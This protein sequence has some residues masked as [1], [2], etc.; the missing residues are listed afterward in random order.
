VGLNVVVGGDHSWPGPQL[1]SSTPDGRYE[2][3]AAIW[4]FFAAHRAGSLRTPDAR[5]SSVR[6]KLGHRT[7]EVALTLSLGERLTIRAALSRNRCTVG[8]VHRSL[9]P[10]DAVHVMLPVPRN[11]S[12][13]PYSISILLT[14]AYGRTLRLARP[15]DLARAPA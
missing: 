10:G 7:R 15:I 14:D 4:A 1:G 13:G 2:A 5:L 6:V 8:V 11:A 9:P 3:S 12:A